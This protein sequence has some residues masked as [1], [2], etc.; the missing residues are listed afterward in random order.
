MRQRALLA[1]CVCAAIGLSAPAALGATK[2]H[3]RYRNALG[4]IPPVNGQGNFNTQEPNEAGLLTPVVYHG[5][6]TMTGGVEVHA[7]FWTPQGTNTSFPVGPNG[8]ST[9]DM[10]SQFFQDSS[11]ASTGTSGAP[12]PCDSAHQSNCNMFTVEPQFGWG[13]TPGHITSG[14]N[15]INFNPATTT[16]PSGFNP[17]ADVIH[18]TNP[19]P[20]G[21]Q[22]TSPLAAKYCI[23]DSQVQ[24]EVASLVTAAGGKAAGKSGLRNLWYVFL[25][26]DVDE[27]IGPDVCGTNAFGGYHSLSN[28]NAGNGVTIYAITI[29]P[30]IETGSISQ[31]AD[32]Q[33][34]PTAEV[35]IDIAAHETNEAMSDPQGTGY[36]N[37]NGWEIGDMC[38]FGPQRGTPLGFAANGSPFNQLINGHQYFIQEMWSNDGDSNNPT[39][40]CVQ[41]TNENSN[42]LPL[43]QVNLR[44]FNKKVGGNTET[45]ISGMPVTVTLLRG[46]NPV[47][48]ASTTTSKGSWSVSLSH[49]IGDDRDELD[50]DYNNDNSGPGVPSPEHQV[51]L[52]GNGGNPFTQSGWTGWTALDNGEFLTN[53]QPFDSL[54]DPG[55]PALIMGPCF[56]TGVLGFTLNGAAQQ[57]P[58]DFCGTES[59]L[60]VQPIAPVANS[61][62]VTVGSNDNRT[63]QPQDTGTPNLT[64]SL[65][66]LSV[67]V[68]EPD[69]LSSFLS[70]I[71]P[72]TGFPTC[73]GDL[74]TQTLTCTG[75]VGGE[76]YTVT[77]GGQT[78]H[79]TADD[80]GMVTQAMAINRGDSIGLSNGSRTLTTLHV[81]NLQVNI[82]DS[83]PDGVGTG[84]CSPDLYWGGPLDSEPTNGSAG[85]AG[86][87]GT[88]TVCPSSGDA[89]DLPLP[90]AQTDEKSGGVTEVNIADVADMS[91]M[92]AETVYGAFTALAEA[93]AGT[94]TISVSIA[95]SAGG[96]PVFSAANVDTANGVAVPAL[97]P[98]TYKA[99]WTV[100]DSVGDTRTLTTRFIEQ[101]GTQGPQGPQGPQGSQGN[102]GQQGSQGPAGSNGNT[103]PQG[104]R[105]PQGPAGPKP[106]IT[107]KL[108]GRHH[109]QIKCTVTFPKKAK[110]V[111][112]SLR[113][114][115]ARGRTVAA[116]GHA[117]L[118]HGTATVT[119]RELHR[120]SKG[121]W[122]ITLVMSLAHQR[123][124][125]FSFTARMG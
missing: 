16:F 100:R 113:V 72:T 17:A 14:D 20:G 102:P 111:S 96:A 94:P 30:T 44:Q 85:D 48:T 62:T 15:T 124:Q 66:N 105:G 52:T 32:P 90:A 51:I 56:Q 10:L 95:P 19:I 67:P 112:G 38:E 46:G 3:P 89:S 122:R 83:D 35:D 33:G 40:S 50:V 79:P 106:R 37:P 58:T 78:L 120:L 80:T 42:P 60:A 53:S 45:G 18:D 103:G 8:K 104:P 21:T 91:P 87:A 123:P 2:F 11:A 5:G 57:S 117:R 25:P 26:A 92:G 73:T 47:A 86:V 115:I 36:M 24:T 27:C 107:C 121:A 13:T 63:F 65:V 6:A 93:T 31:G 116:L 68:G 1:A 84:V 110:D 70:A 61:D 22:C 75:L 39:P 12:G 77:D 9:P 41:G 101:P 114:R 49:A 125:T 88:G 98:G 109:R 81:A 108:T 74:A 54:P 34:N 99:T 118:R 7:I 28:V 76:A 97:T 43:P 55:N 64:G 119:M 71:T 4:L 59:D 82:D 69:S 23:L 29:D